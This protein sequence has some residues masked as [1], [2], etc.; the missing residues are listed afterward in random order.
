MARKRKKTSDEAFR[1]A[2]LVVAPGTLI[3]EAVSAIIQSGTG[4]LLCFGEPRRLLNLSEGGVMLDE[5]VTPQILYEL[6]KMD[7]AILL[8]ETGTRILSANRF[9]KPNAKIHSDETGTRHRTAQRLAAQ[10]QCVVIAVSQRRSSVT[11]YCHDKRHVLDTISTL[12]NKAMQ[13]VATLEKYMSVL[14]QAMQEL[15]TREFQDVVTIFDVC[16]AIQRTE[17]VVRIAKEIEP[18]ILELGT[19]G[20]LIDLQLR[21]LLLPVQEAKLVV[22]DYA[23]DK[24][25][26]SGKTALDKVSVIPQ[27]DLLHLGNISQALGYGPNLRSIDTYLSP[28]GYRVLTATHRLQPQIIE[29]LVMRF[30][31]LQAVMRAPKDDLVEV[32]GVGE[33]LAE[34]VRVS[35]NLLRNQLVV[36]ERR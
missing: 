30:G 26:A 16:K 23:R 8:D 34:R 6:S 18:Y 10:A 19:E 2:L 29:N 1:D 36:D 32:D 24:P 5:P 15:T 13:A 31:S 27:Q 11:L 12:M 22:K 28:R 9:L 21:E 17:M 14:H 35:L 33:V 3:R 20:R 7:G 4:A 25:G